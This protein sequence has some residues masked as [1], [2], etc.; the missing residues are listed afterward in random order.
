MDFLVNPS[1]FSEAEMAD[2][3]MQ[4]TSDELMYPPGEI[5]GFL[6]WSHQHKNMKPAY[7]M[8]TLAQVLY[9]SAFS[10]MV[11]RYWCYE[12]KYGLFWDNPF[13]QTRQQSLKQTN[14]QLVA[15]P[16]V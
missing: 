2:I 11:T 14:P 6:F 7:R 15:L 12:S 5:K 13:S 8:S 10:S 16:A 3:L 9:Y 1:T 4:K